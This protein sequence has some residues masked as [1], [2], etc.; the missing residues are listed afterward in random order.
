MFVEVKG[1][2]TFVNLNGRTFDPALPSIVFVHGAAMEQSVWAAQARYFAY[3]DYNSLAVN[4]PAHG[5]D[6]SPNKSAGEAP[7]TIPGYADWIIAFMDAMEL[8]TAVL[9]GHS[10]G[11]LISME[12]AAT[13]PD[14]ISKLMLV[15]AAPSMPVHPALVDAASKDDWLA[16][17]L[18]TSW[19]HG[20]GGHRGGNK[21]NGIWMKGTALSVFGNSEN[22]LIYNDLSACA[23]Y[24]TGLDAAAK[25]SCPTLLIAG[26]DDKMTPAR[27]GAKLA[28]IIPDSRYELLPV[29]H[30]MMS[31]APNQVLDFMIDFLK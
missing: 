17:E 11:T 21:A 30:M 4:M 15:G 13:Y 31:E 19:G 3:H 7:N 26:K 14:R 25:I 22:Q 20:D 9:A 1:H 28:G 18:M 10:M 27:Q 2:N 16:E 23:N 29:G 6:G 5:P 12:A 24:A 8:K